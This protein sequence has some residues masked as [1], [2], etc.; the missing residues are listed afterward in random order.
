MYA[1]GCIIEMPKSLA[2][3]IDIMALIF[4]ERPDEIS[5]EAG[6]VKDPD[7]KTDRYIHLWWD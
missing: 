3:R 2:K 4:D 6:I 5:S 7:F 1:E